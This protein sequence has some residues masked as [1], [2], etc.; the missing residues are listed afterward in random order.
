MPAVSVPFREWGIVPA[1]L[2]NSDVNRHCLDD[3]FFWPVHE[4]A[5]ALDMRIYLHI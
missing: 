3:K 1:T 5:E 4:G 2:I